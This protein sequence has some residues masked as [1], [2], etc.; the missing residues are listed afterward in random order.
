MVIMIVGLGSGVGDAIQRVRRVMRDGYSTERFGYKDRGHEWTR[1]QPMWEALL[2]IILA[3]RWRVIYLLWL[4]FRCR[5][6]NV[7]GYKKTGVMWLLDSVPL[8]G[9]Q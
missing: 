6:G 7:D 9:V 1:Y 5:P 2:L 4:L 3:S 8:S